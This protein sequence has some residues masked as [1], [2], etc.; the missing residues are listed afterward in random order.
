MKGF[1]VMKLLEDRI[2]KDGRI[3]SGNILKVDT[4]LGQQID[5][6]FMTELAQEWKRLFECEKITKILTIEASGIGIACIAGV[7]FNVPVVYAKKTSSDVSKDCYSS[8][9]VSY[10][11][12]TI[13]NVN[14]P[15]SIISA[16]DNVLIIDD[17]LANGSA[18]KALIKLTEQAGAKVIGAGIAIE[19]TYLGAADKI[20]NE[21]YRI[22]SLAKIAKVDDISGITFI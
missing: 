6:P 17:L 20:R 22:E 14:I 19:K 2:I 5:A 21:G 10:T 4:F 16:D 9:I 8:K 18:L 1:I 7:C 12:G 15:K 13:Y 3:L 11:H